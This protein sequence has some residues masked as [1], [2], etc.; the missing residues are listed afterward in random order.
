MAFYQ[1]TLDLDS[2]QVDGDLV[3]GYKTDLF[4]FA[5]LC[6]FKTLLPLPPLSKIEMTSLCGSRNI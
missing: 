5:Y 3:S 1:W 4:L 6:L 2:H